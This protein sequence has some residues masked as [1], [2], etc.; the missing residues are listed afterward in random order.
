[1][2]RYALVNGAGQVVSWCEWDGVAPWTPPDG[3]TALPEAQ[4]AG[5]PIYAPPVPVPQTI[6]RRQL[7]MVLWQTGTITAQE[8]ADAAKT[9]A[10]PAAIQSYFALLPD[11]ERMA[12]E[13]TWASMSVA[14]RG[15]PLIAAL[16]AQL[17]LTGAQVDDFFRLAATL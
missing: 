11:A 13:I 3:M 2:A 4:A 9:G 5:L 12:A 14:E 8:A 1:M 16:A 17:G 7:I 10:V 6:T 15:N